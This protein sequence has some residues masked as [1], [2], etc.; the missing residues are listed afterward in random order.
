MIDTPIG[1][2]ASLNFVSKEFRMTNAF[3]KE[4]K[5]SPKLYIRVA[6]D[7]RISTIKVFSPTIFIIGG[8][9][10]IDLQFRVISHFKSTDIILG[11]STL[12]KSNF[13]I[14]PSLNKFSMGDFQVHGK[15]NESLRNVISTN[16][17]FYNKYVC[18]RCHND[19][20]PTR[21]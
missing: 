11:L 15:N 20:N 5:T 14:R 7:Q 12:K 8:Y 2:A 6:S 4:F 3:Y 18:R 10:F 9:E 1:T 19:D 13:A 21:I 16:K 17:S